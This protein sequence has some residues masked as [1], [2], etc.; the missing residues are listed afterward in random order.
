MSAL[1]PSTVRDVV[2]DAPADVPDGLLDA[3][4]AYDEALLANDVAALD[5]AFAPGPGTIRGDGT[6]VVVGWEAISRFRAARTVV[7]TRRV[8][9]VHVRIPPTAS[10]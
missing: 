5:D 4:W 1:A 6:T 3:F 9:A 2:V 8:T 7:P 10:R